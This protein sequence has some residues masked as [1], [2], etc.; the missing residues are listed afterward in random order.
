MSKIIK[1]RSA[2]NSFLQENINCHGITVIKLEKVDNVWEAVAEVY[3][4]DSF[5]KSM[6]LPT[7]NDRVFYSFKI[8]EQ[9][10]IISFERM[11]EYTQ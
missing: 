10:E 5:L 7:K 9:Y 2:V 3:E 1:V 11:K 6:N 8:D 4:E